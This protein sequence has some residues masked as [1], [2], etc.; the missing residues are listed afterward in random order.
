MFYTN[1]YRI[2]NL[3]IN[4]FLSDQL[5]I[6]LVDQSLETN[7]WNK[8][9]DPRANLLSEPT[10]LDQS[11][12][13]FKKHLIVVFWKT[14]NSKICAAS[15]KITGQVK[16]LENNIIEYL[17]QIFGV[18]NTFNI[19]EMTFC[20]AVFKI[21]LK[22]DLLNEILVVYFQY[23][24]KIFYSI[25]MY[26]A[27]H[28]HSQI[29]LEQLLILYFMLQFCKLNN[30]IRK[31]FLLKFNLQDYTNQMDKFSRPGRFNVDPN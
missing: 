6:S 31:L 29:W 20:F 5:K 10:S 16:H 28:S 24:V 13:T 7:F 14:E 4:T 15:S 22:K 11:D 18:T 2:H 21:V 23:I 26:Y 27:K 17:K 1:I 8:P 12:P 19:G 9:R 25:M 3:R 30:W